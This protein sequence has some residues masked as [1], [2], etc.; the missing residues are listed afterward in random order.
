MPC[1]T[2]RRGHRVGEGQR[3][4][5]AATGFRSGCLGHR[6]VAGCAQFVGQPFE[7]RDGVLLG[8]RQQM[9]VGVR[10]R[11]QTGLVGV[12]EEGRRRLGADEDHMLQSGQ[13]L[14]GA[15]D[16]IRDAVHRGSPAP[17]GHARY[18]RGCAQLG[19]RHVADPIGGTQSG[20]AQAL[21]GQHQHRRLPSAERLRHGSQQVGRHRA[22]GSTSRCGS[23]PKGR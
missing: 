14:Q 11:Q 21:A 3:V 22:R 8:P 5:C 18:L 19:A 9:N 1:G 20:L 2:G 6:Q 7:R 10:R 17:A 16:R 12:G 15:V 13:H 23:R 4:E